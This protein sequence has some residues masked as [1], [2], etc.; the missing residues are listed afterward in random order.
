MD[1]TFF[2]IWIVSSLGGAAVFAHLLRLRTK[3]TRIEPANV[4]AGTLL[5][6][7]G[8][9]RWDFLKNNGIVAKEWDD[10]EL[11]Y[12][13]TVWSL[14]FTEVNSI[15]IGTDPEPGT[16]LAAL[17]DAEKAWMKANIKEPK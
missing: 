12:K 4:E 17:S 6:T 9:A 3:K 10:L 13:R 14:A 11:W 1:R 2:V 5:N 16:L 7:L 8:R 15:P